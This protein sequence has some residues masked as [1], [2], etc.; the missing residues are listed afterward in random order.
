MNLC[1][2]AET[3]NLVSIA[4]RDILFL[5]WPKTAAIQ[6][7]PYQ[8]GRKPKRPYIHKHF[9]YKC[10]DWWLYEYIVSCKVYPFA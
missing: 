6:K 4:N 5:Y 10:D 3:H 9:I 2:F 1:V 7:G 8:K